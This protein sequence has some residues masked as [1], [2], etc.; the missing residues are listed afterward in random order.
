MPYQDIQFQPL[1]QRS[2]LTSHG[3]VY[4][5]IQNKTTRKHGTYSLNN[6]TMGLPLS[7]FQRMSNL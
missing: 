3:H 4:D 6:P 7:N 1:P 2:P 5:P